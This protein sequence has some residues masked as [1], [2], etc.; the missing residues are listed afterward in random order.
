MTVNEQKRAFSEAWLRAIAACS[1]FGV[2]DGTVPDD[3]S[4]DITITS[5]LDGIVTKPRLDAQLKCTE[6][7][8]LKDGAIKFPLPQKNY[9]DLRDTHASVPK[10]LVVL[11]VP[12]DP[13]AWL[14]CELTR[15]EMYKAAWWYSLSGLPDS[16]NDE[17]T[18]VSIPDT[19]RFTVTVLRDMMRKLSEGQAL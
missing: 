10:I 17:N 11:Q 3:Q 7:E 8:L 18:T 14:R 16:G 6:K 19:Q 13:I 9:D 2:Q 4:V 15:L 12:E 5:K 1:G